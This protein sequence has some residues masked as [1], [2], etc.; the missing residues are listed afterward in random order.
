MKHAKLIEWL[1]RFAIITIAVFLVAHA[2]ARGVMTG[3]PW[4]YSALGFSFGWLVSGAA[5]AAIDAFAERWSRG[6]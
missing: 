4:W 3:E 1:L 2:T 5:G 6:R